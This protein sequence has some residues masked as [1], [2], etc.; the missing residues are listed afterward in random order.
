[1]YM[2]ANKNSILIEVEYK[3][4]ILIDTLSSKVCKLQKPKLA[5]LV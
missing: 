5:T 1:M 2:L 4:R 3:F